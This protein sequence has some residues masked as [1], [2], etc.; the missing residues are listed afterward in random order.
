MGLD[1]MN[2]VTVSHEKEK[3]L[4]L[5]ASIVDDKFIDFVASSP[6]N[7]PTFWTEAKKNWPKSY[8]SFEEFGDLEIGKGGKSLFF[9]FTTNYDPPEEIYFS[10]IKKGYLVKADYTL[11]GEE[12]DWD[13][14][15]NGADIL[16]TW[17]V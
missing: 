16:R 9:S 13:W 2:W 17:T 5:L 1:C 10:L 15:P 14:N 4:E 8:L 12:G 3:I 11:E 6:V 7:D